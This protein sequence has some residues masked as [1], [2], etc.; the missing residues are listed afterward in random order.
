MSMRARSA[1]V[2]G[3]AIAFVFLIMIVVNSLSASGI[4]TPN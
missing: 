1:F 3:I 2:A 4:F